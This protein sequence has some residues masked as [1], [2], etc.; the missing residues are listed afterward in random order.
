MITYNQEHYLREAVESVLAQ[1][2]AFD[3][4]LVIGEDCST[5]RTRE[6]ALEF[7]RTYPNVVRVLPNTERLGLTRNFE[8]TLGAC[9]GEYVAL[10]DGDDFW[11]NPH[12]LQRQVEVLDNQPD[13]SVVFHPVKIVPESAPQ[14]T[15]LFPAGLR[16]QRTSIQ[17]V[18]HGHYTHT[19]SVMVRSPRLARLPAWLHEVYV[20][21]WP[22]VLLCARRGDIYCIPDTMATYRPTG[23]GIWSSLSYMERA[24]HDMEACLT[25]D[26]GLSYQ[27]SEILVPRALGFCYSLA[28]RY[29]K[30]GLLAEAKAHLKQYWRLAPVFRDWKAKLRLLL[31]IQYP[32]AWRVV[33]YLRRR[34]I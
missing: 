2:T 17:D 13:I 18:L 4:E 5:D 14:R 27:Y 8:R 33:Q 25:I 3:F 1:Q 34:P 10:L 20:H 12:K 29:Q 24:K 26:R 7:Q 28:I 16:P 21:D 19:A 11:T 6:V 9:R 15:R 23:T 32:R 30:A 31:G 22:F